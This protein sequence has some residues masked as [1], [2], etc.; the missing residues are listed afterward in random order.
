MKFF[1]VNIIFILL[2]KGIVYLYNIYIN[3]FINIFI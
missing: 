1:S 3:I 2:E